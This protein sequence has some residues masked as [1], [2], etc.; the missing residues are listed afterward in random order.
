MA[1]MMPVPAGARVWDTSEVTSSKGFDYYHGAICQAFSHLLPIAEATTRQHF[2]AKVAS[3]P[4]GAGF[5]NYVQSTSHL[6]VRTEQEI[7]RG[8]VDWYYLNYSSG[9]CCIIDQNDGTATIQAGDV[10]LF[11][12]A[13]P[14]TLEHRRR[15]QLSVVSFMIPRQALSDRLG[16][17]EVSKPRV[18]SNHPV[19]G[20]LLRET[21]RTLAEKAA[22]IPPQALPGLFETLV[23]F[24]A[25]AVS[26]QAGAERSGSRSRA[27]FLALR[28]HV[29]RHFRA[30]DFDVARLAAAHGVSVRYVHKLFEAHGGGESFGDYIAGQRLLWAAERLRSAAAQRDAITD[31]AFEAGFADLTQFYRAFRRRFGCAPGAF[32]HGPDAS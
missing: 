27:L 29:D 12:G 18:V 19:F 10:G 5:I 14:F 23:D 9:G 24:A 25:L 17:A 22:G 7:A 8:D 6:V 20:A 31:I 2:S 28:A 11:S 3:V 30:P 32:R 1:R 26:P 15:P 13:A 4:V 16:G 21:A